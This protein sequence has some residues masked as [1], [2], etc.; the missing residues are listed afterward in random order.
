MFSFTTKDNYKVA[1]RPE[2]TP[3]LARLVTNFP[4]SSLR[5]FILLVPLILIFFRLVLKKGRKLLMPIRWYS[6]P[7][8]WRFETIQR[9]R[10]REHYQWNMDIMGVPDVCTLPL[11]S[12]Q[13]FYLHRSD[14]FPKNSL[15][16]FLENLVFLC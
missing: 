15:F 1:L 8:C 3:S 12:L 4:L 11:I 5:L 14:L 16:Y 9:G 6:I 2:M 13:N 7:Q 10:R